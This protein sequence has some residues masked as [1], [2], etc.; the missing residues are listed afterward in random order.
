[1]VDE[2]DHHGPTIQAQRNPQAS[3]GR[4]SRGGTQTS[5]RHARYERSDRAVRND[6]QRLADVLAAAEA[7]AD[8]LERG[9]LTDGLV[10][11]AVGERLIEIGEAVKAISPLRDP[12]FRLAKSALVALSVSLGS[13]GV[14]GR[15]RR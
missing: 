13:S 3:C 8:H 2:I 15:Y 14:S 1:M 7:I 5:C 11:D 10:F 6:A 12:R 4:R 9:S